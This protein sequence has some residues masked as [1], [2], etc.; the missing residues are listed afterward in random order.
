MVV[1]EE[2][3]DGGGLVAKEMQNQLLD[4]LECQRKLRKKKDVA[5]EREEMNGVFV[6]LSEIFQPNS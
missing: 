2:R 5:E 4:P 3:E 1:A 6:R